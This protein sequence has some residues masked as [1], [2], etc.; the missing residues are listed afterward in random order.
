MLQRTLGCLVLAVGVA[1]WIA[2]FLLGVG[3]GMAESNDLALLLSAVI[4]LGLVGLVFVV[5][6]AFGLRHNP[7]TPGPEA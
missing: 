1:C 4:P 5:G 2:A 3:Y 6:G 7:R